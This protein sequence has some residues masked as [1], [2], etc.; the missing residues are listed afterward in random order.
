MA[1]FSFYSMM[2]IEELRERDI[3]RLEAELTGM[4]LENAL[5]KTLH[6]NIE[7]LRDT[8]T[9]RGRR[10]AM[11]LPVRGQGTRNNVSQDV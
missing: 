1:K 10:H 2:R 5:R 7:R 11:R 9:Y 6:E 3:K 4:T 8:G